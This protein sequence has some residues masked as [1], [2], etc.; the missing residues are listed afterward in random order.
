MITAG[1]LIN[2][3]TK[4]PYDAPSGLNPRTKELNVLFTNVKGIKIAAKITVNTLTFD[5]SATKNDIT[6]YMNI[7][8]AEKN[9]L[10][11]IAVFAEFSFLAVSRTTQYSIVEL[12]I[13]PYTIK[14]LINPQ[15]PNSSVDRVLVMIIVTT[16]PVITLASLIAKEI[17]PEYVTRISLK[18][19]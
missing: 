18:L 15:A 11:T 14:P 12:I 2:S 1:I 6:K 7:P 19:C 10:D 17:S 3:K 8:I 9:V 13:I 4:N 5:S 16:N